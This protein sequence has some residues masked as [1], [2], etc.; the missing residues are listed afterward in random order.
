MDPIFLEVDEILRIHVDQIKRYGGTEGLRDRGLLESAIAMPKATF[1][2]DFLHSDIFEMAAAYL[3]HIVKNH[4]FLDGNK[5]TGAVASVVFLR[6]NDWQLNARE[7]AFEAL[8]R[9]VAD[10]TC[11]KEQAAEF[12][13]N[14]CQEL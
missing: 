14:Q 4:P 10:G 9:S 7:E 3:F 2:G 5:R 6:L 11:N 12:F 13:R 1:S 8:A